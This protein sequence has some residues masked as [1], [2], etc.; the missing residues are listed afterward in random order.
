MGSIDHLFSLKWEMVSSCYDSLWSP[1]NKKILLQ[2]SE[3]GGDSCKSVMI[4]SRKYSMNLGVVM[5]E[6]W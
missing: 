3:R 4:T 5:K 1:G 6:T 2:I